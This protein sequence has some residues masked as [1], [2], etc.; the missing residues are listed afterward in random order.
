MGGLPTI[1]VVLP[2][3]SSI[4]IGFSIIFTIRFVF[5]PPIFGNI[6]IGSKEICCF[7]TFFL[8]ISVASSV[9]L[10]MSFHS[11]P[12]WA[13]WPV[14]TFLGKSSEHQLPD[15]FD[16]NTFPKALPNSLPYRTINN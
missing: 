16:L 7:Q 11:E 4:S 3:K 2:P 12:L 8:Y 15:S 1:G 6:H 10:S 13:Q 9:K 14:G 5:F